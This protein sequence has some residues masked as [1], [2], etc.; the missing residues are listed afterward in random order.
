MTEQ[1][2][3]SP[4]QGAFFADEGTTREP[5]RR[6][7]G[8]IVGDAERRSSRLIPVASATG[9]GEQ[10]ANAEIREIVICERQGEAMM[11]GKNWQIEGRYVEYCSCD[12]YK[13]KFGRP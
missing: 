7:R 9:S 3:N 2:I 6:G 4:E 8:P 1:G 11:A 5:P 10:W 12:E 13:L